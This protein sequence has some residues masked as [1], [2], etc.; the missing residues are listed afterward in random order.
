MKNEFIA[1]D[2]YEDF[3]CKCG[4]CRNSC[5]LGWPISVSMK[6]YFNLIGIECSDKL[7]HEIECALHLRD[8]PE[9]GDY[10]VISQNWLGDCPM[11]GKDGL[12]ALQRECGEG[13]LPRLCRVYPR[14]L[15]AA[16]GLK[17]AVCS[18]SC[19]KVI[20][21]MMNRET[22]LSFGKIYIDAEPEITRDIDVGFILYEYDALKTL[23]RRSLPLS[24]R[25]RIICGF[26]CVNAGN[27]TASSALCVLSGMLLSMSENSASL[28]RF[29]ADSFRRYSGSGA[30]ERYI[31]DSER[32]SAL[33]PDLES[34]Y[35]NILANHMFYE[36]FP[37]SDERIA[38]R[39]ERLSLA[40]V[41]AVLR[42]VTVGY[43]AE[44]SERSDFADAAAGAFRFIE[45][46]AFYLN[47][48]AALHAVKLA[49]ENAAA[50]L[51]L[52]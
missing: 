24:E 20:E 1:P 23:R 46:T 28:S 3:M 13:V 37:L 42:F 12:C 16:G 29:G 2:Y 33:M 45:H 30:F 50:A 36:D 48:A 17:K 43:M 7:H 11:H 38:A 9:S 51:L 18:N 27:D 32:L 41:Y 5:C 44:R 31:K 47:A 34:A 15:E 49:D 10:A 19:E 26:P 25:L 39:D 40:A 4:E 22:P 14:R 8:E 21:L 52:L 35:E 6:E